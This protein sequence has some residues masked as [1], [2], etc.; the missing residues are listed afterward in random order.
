MHA[1]RLFLQSDVLHV[2]VAM[3]NIFEKYAGDAFQ[4]APEHHLPGATFFAAD[5]VQHQEQQAAQQTLQLDAE[6]H[7]DTGGSSHAVGGN[8]DTA[9]GLSASDEGASTSTDS[10]SDDYETL[11]SAW[12]A[13]GWLSSNPLGVPT[14]REHY[15]QQKGLPVYRVLL[16]RK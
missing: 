3:R 11:D 4:L 8:G 14:E 12:A 5:A 15:V 7:A 2:A 10:D 1:G 9:V 16:T 6:Q 13:A